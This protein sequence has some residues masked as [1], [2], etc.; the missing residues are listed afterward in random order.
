MKRTVR[1]PL[2]FMRVTAAAEDAA[3]VGHRALD[4]VEPLEV[5]LGAARDDLRQRG[6]AHAGRPEKNQRRE[7]VRL[8]QPPQ[9]LARREQ[10]ALADVFLQRARPKARREG[11][12]GGNRAPRAFRA[13][14]E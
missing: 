2:A 7:P 5:A 12:V 13:G 1:L 6:F 9:R 3:Q 11:S 8:D 14:A 4:A 10:M